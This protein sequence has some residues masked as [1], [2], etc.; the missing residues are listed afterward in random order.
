MEQEN[1][2]KTIEWATVVEYFTKRGRPLTKDEVRRL[3]EE[4]RKMREEA[5]EQKRLAAEQERRRAQRLMA[6]LE[7]DEDF[8]AFEARCNKADGAEVTGGGSGARDTRGD[9]DEAS[10]ERGEPEDE[11]EDGLSDEFERD[12][13]SA[14]GTGLRRAHSAKQVR[15]SKARLTAD[16]Y[17]RAEEG[18][19]GKYGVTVPKPFAFDIREKTR[20]KS[21]R[22]RKVEGMVEE[23]RIEEDGR[24]RHVFRCKPIP[25]EVL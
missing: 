15:G 8:E 13:E 12:D 3:Q 20:A 10:E 19:K 17:V 16:D 5:E 24:L 14:M 1:P 4:D 7:Q 18:R 9:E 11:G 6:D 25:P 23:R 2:A 21:I 22:E